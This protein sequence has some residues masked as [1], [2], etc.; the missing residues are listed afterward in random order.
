MYRKHRHMADHLTPAQL[1]RYAKRTLSPAELLASDDH[2][3]ACETC[4]QRTGDPQTEE[5]AFDFLRQDLAAQAKLGLSH[6]SYAQMES[7]VDNDADTADREIVD[8]HVE[9]CR[10][11]REELR[12]L[13]EFR[14]SLGSRDLVPRDFS[15]DV[16]SDFTGRKFTEPFRVHDAA[17]DHVED[18][19]TPQLVRPVASEDKNW[20]RGHRIWRYPGFLTGAGAAVAIV[21]VCVLY[22]RN[23][24]QQTKTTSLKPEAPSMQ[25]TPDQPPEKA[26]D[27]STSGSHSAVS[28]TSRPWSSAEIASFMSTDLTLKTPDTLAALIGKSGTLLGS[29]SQ[30]VPFTLLAP[31]GTFVENKQPEFRWHRMPGAVSYRVNVFDETLKEVSGSS[32]LSE[33]YWNGAAGLQGGKVYLW[34]VTTTKK[35]GEKIV[36]PAP[37]TPEAKFE[38]LEGTP[39]EQ[40][41]ELKHKQPNAHFMLGRA[42]AYVG[43][44]DEAE[45]EFRLVSSSDPNY[46]LAQ[47]FIRDLKILRNPE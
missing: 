13:Q 40:L 24:A 26:V 3:S 9:L 43:L 6:V 23:Q 37:P 11:C 5:A 16:S 44:L 36:V 34:Q 46:A 29:N 35:N 12:E 28:S 25:G 33:T 2:L 38:V 19:N 31:V 32:A 21:L 10:T 7:Y 15:D 39:I 20:Q 47:K 14:V 1:A 41:E 22:I 18:Q 30:S 17:D 4:R 42:C 45:R 27:R 8:S